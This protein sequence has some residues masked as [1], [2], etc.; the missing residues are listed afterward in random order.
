MSYSCDGFDELAAVLPSGRVAP[1]VPRAAKKIVDTAGA[2]GWL[3]LVQWAEA[4]GGAPFLGVDVGIAL[5]RRHYRLTWH[6]FQVAQPL[7]DDLGRGD[8]S[9][10]RL[11]LFTKIVTTGGPWRDA[12]SLTEITTVITST[13]VI[14]ARRPAAAGPHDG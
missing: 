2:A 14:T 10:V 1:A 6:T 11:Q 7:L 9:G 8:V 12:P 4:S 13:E 5:P 3:T